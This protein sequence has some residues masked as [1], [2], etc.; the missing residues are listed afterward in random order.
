M[1]EQVFQ[2]QTHYTVK[3]TNKEP[4]SIPDIIRSLKSAERLLHRTPA[5]IEKAFDGIEILEMQVYVDT[6]ESGSLYER[7]IINYVFRGKKNYKKQKEV[8]EHMLNDSTT[9]KVVV[10][11]GMS[12]AFTYGVMQASGSSAPTKHIEAYN[13]T[14]V[15]IGGSV[16]LTGEDIAMVLDGIRD[17]KALAKESIDFIKPAKADPDATIEISGIDALTVDKAFIRKAPAEYE[18]PMPEEK[19]E[20][21]SDRPVVIWASD[22]EKSDS[23]WAGTVLNIVDK[24]TKFVLDESV[25]PSKLHGRVRFN[26][27]IVVTSR[28]QKSKKDYEPVTVRITKVYPRVAK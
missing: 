24:R 5:F 16:D 4:V 1:R 6:M 13:N 28:Y 15:N 19:D 2:V 7:F 3:Y 11:A 22:R 27:D 12:A 9:L 17:K 18:P 21:Y 8:I 10:A 14:I 20:R 23:V 26:A 25:D